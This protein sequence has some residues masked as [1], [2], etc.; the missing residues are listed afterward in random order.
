MK[1]PYN[2]RRSR[3]SVS[4]NGRKFGLLSLIM[5]VAILGISCRRAASVS[6]NHA[7]G[8]PPAE[9]IAEADR[10]YH[11]RADLMKVRQGVVALRRAQAE[12]Q[13]NYELA[14]RVA[15]FNYYLGSHSP[16]ATERDKAFHDGIEAGKLAVD[17]Q[18]GKPDGHFW[19]GANYGGKAQTSMLSGLSE[20]DDI[21]QEMETVLKLDEG[22]E[23]GSA[24]MVL[25]QV[26]LEAPGLLG[27]DTQK[28][29]HYLEKGLKFGP[30]NS[31]LR[32]ELAAA[33]ADAHR[34][35]DARKQIDALLAMKPAPGY[36]PEHE[37]ALAKVRE[38]EE[39]IK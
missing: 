24:Y 30:D 32:A 11:G 29:I 33:Y 9:A 13:A 31:L 35:Q 37:E 20:I 36:E 8:R 14:W 4:E 5:A 17:L 2:S 16:D 18:D 7:A 22:Y 6:E 3:I 12:D 39:K 27:G 38:L 23:S 10:L 15:M 21:K 19:L 28:A 25:G 26:Y 34:S 1:R